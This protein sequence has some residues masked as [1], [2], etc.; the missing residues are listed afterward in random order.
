MNTNQFR[1][2]FSNYLL[3]SCTWPFYFVQ[4][5]QIINL[6]QSLYVVGQKINK[7]N[8]FLLQTYYFAF[9]KIGRVS[10]QKKD[11]D[12]KKVKPTIVLVDLTELY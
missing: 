5:G 12:N 8:G 11:V 4:N 9:R 3:G 2:I 7:N 1:I 10:N 6:Y